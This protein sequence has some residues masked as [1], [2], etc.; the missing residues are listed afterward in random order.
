MLIV[1]DL[2]DFGHIA[3]TNALSDVYAIGIPIL[4]LAVLDMPINR[5]LMEGIQGIGS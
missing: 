5:L 4:A 1:A 3:A 2:V